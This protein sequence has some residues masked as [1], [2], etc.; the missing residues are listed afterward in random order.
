MPALLAATEPRVPPGHRARLA[1]KA[2][3]VSRVK[4]VPLGRPGPRAR[5]A[6]KGPRGR[7]EQRVRKEKREPPGPK[8]KLARTELQALRVT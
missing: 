4:S 1:L 6:Q 5:L 7:P 8:E 3:R 2:C